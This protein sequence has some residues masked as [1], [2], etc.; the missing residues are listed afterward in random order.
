[1][2][3]QSILQ[4]NTESFS[5]IFK[6][7]RSIQLLIDP[8]SGAILK[9]NHA[10]ELFYGYS[11]E[12]LLA[13][14]IFDLNCLE[15]VELKVILA[16][17]ASQQ[18]HDFIFKHRLANGEIRNVEVRSDPIQ[19][20]QDIV[21]YSIIHDIT[22]RIQAQQALEQTKL[23][24]E[25]TNLFLQSLIDL[26]P[27]GIVVYRQDCILLANAYMLKRVG[28]SCMDDLDGKDVIQ[29]IHPD[30]REAASQRIRKVLEDGETFHQVPVR[31]LNASGDT[32]D[33]ELS[34]TPIQYN[35]APAILSVTMEVTAR[36]RAEESLRK[37]SLAIE[38]AGES[39]VI[40]D[41]HGLID[42]VNP[43]FTRITGF[44]KSDVVGMFARELRRDH[45]IDQAIRACILA[46]N[47]WQGEV[48]NQKK[49][50]SQYPAMLTVSPIIDADGQ[51]THF[52]GIEFDLSEQKN[53]EQQFYQAQK[54]DEIGTL[55]GGIAHDF[56]NMLAG[57][58]GNIYLAK[59]DAKALPEVVSK[60][61]LMEQSSHRAADMIAQLLTFARKGVVEM[62]S[63]HIAP[64]IKEAIKLLYASIPENI[65]FEQHVCSESLSVKADPTQLHQVLMNLVNNARDA[66]AGVDHPCIAVRLESFQT[67]D[68]FLETH[69]YF[70]AGR[71]ARLSVSDNGCGMSEVQQQHIFEPFFTTKD[72]GKGTGLG[73]AMVIGAI[74]THHGFIEVD[75]VPGN[76]STFHVFL[77]LLGQADKT[78]GLPVAQQCHGNG[79]LVLVVDDEELLCDV[80]V[81][82]LKALGYKALAATDGMQA[83]ELFK[84]HR[85]DITIA[86]L[87]VVMPRMG[88]VE[89]AEQIRAIAPNLPIIFLTGY[90]A[91]SSSNRIVQNAYTMLLSKP[92]G[93]SALSTYLSK[94][95]AKQ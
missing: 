95:L 4:I 88:G 39:V 61:D 29:F 32:L 10:A 91:S 1:M 28:L 17:V 30:D 47:V 80:N 8:Q 94:M 59:A 89:L 58:L 21:L 25:S 84:S 76:G 90:D 49:D 57:I 9:A 23:E 86:L 51:T 40:T 15:K 46:G 31:Y 7:N 79:A 13:L 19:W 22:P 38:Q 60:L 6:V 35:G 44:T 5:H 92:L 20:G 85:N 45:S 34:S 53:L 65:V 41:R 11:Q 2:S 73:L 43:A 24:L 27:V 16:S 87:D 33:F 56:N 68:V 83:L 42:Y 62:K 36:K 67:D 18:Q 71:Y 64:Y 37:L 74:K 77:P 72:I 48:V 81:A 78:A 54:M 69:P 70:K 55:L 26:A 75:S 52:I 14:K 93:I 63:L 12:Q 66:V 50:G 82:V 3:D